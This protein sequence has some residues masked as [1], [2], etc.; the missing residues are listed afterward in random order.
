VKRRRVHLLFMAVSCSCALYLAWQG[1]KLWQAEKS[2]CAVAEVSQIQSAQAAT[3]ELTSSSDARVQLAWAGRLSRMGEHAKAER[4]FGE[5]VSD[6]Q[7]DPVRVIAQY[8]LAN[9]YF[10]QALSATT[11]ANAVMPLVELAKQRYRDVLALQPEHWN[12]RYNLERA[13]RLAPEGGS[14]GVTEQGKPIK[15]V[16]VIVPDFERG[17]L[18]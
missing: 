5:L 10:R 17:A 16:D 14:H 18:P 13:L 9:H 2:Q 6:T 12:A 1:L 7:P 8:N 15:R 3:D 4:L 11:D